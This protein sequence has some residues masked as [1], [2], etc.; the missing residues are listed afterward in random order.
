[1]QEAWHYVLDH[2][3]AFATYGY[4]SIDIS[5]RLISLAI[6]PRNRRPGSAMAWLLAI[7]LLPILA[8]PLYLMLGKA[9]LPKDRGQKQAIVNRLMRV[10]A[11]TIPDSELDPDVP[12]WLKS[13]VRLNRELGAFPLT[14]RNQ[15]DLEIDY[16]RSLARMAADIRS[17]RHDVHAVFYTMALDHVTED[18]FAAVCEAADRGVAVR[19][20]YDH[21]GSFTKG[22]HYR[23]MRRLLSAHGVEHRP[24]MPVRFVRNGAFQ[25]PDL[26]NH[27]KLLIVDGEIGWLGSQNI[28]S[29]DYD[30]RTHR[31]RGLHWQETMARLRGPIVS[32]MNLLFATDWYGETGHALPTESVVRSSPDT[33]GDYECQIVPSGPG[34]VL[35][36]NLLLFNQLFYSASRRIVAVSP[37]FVPEESLLNAMITAAKRGVEVQ[38]FVSEIGDQAIVF[39]AQRSYYQQLL[40]A[41]VRIFLYRAPTILHAKHLTVDDAVTVIG[42]SNMDIRS[43]LLDMESSLMVGG[44]DF[45][46]KM[47][48]VE[49]EY[50]ARSTELT[51]AEWNRRP[52]LVVLVDNLCRLASAVV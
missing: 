21:W 45:M 41:G 33:S 17:A 32:E 29:P 7:M 11:L 23:R 22:K 5:L 10:R 18:F 27:R 51:L 25:R 48:A 46:E 26:R 9:R 30:S 35:E 4:W 44:S 1:M 37:Y 43:F 52:R 12:T 14:G 50:R 15:T 8:F 19:I 40:E 20:L 36:N 42:S 24:A 6:V 2:W 31:R 34:F 49:D 47:R 38:L 39:H 28:I 16:H 3:V 13:A